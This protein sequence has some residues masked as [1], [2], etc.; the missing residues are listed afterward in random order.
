MNLT[1]ARWRSQLLAG[2]VLGAYGFAI[3]LAPGFTAKGVLCA[4]LLAVPLIWWLLADTSHWLIAFFVA[5]WLLPPLPV[6][7]GNSGPHVS[8]LFAGFGVWMGLACLRSWRFRLDGAA[9][10]IVLVLATLCLSLSMALLYS[11]PAIAELS[12]VRVLLFAISVYVYFFVRSGLVPLEMPR[13]VRI[14]FWTGAASALFACVDFY[15]QFPAPAGYGPQFIWL[16]SGVFRRAQG[17]FYEASTLGNLCAFFLVLIA[18]SFVRAFNIRE[19]FRPQAVS[20]LVLGGCLFSAALVLSYSRGSLINVLVA[21][22]A[23]AVL[24]FSSIRFARVLP[25]AAILTIAGALMLALVAPEFAQAY[26]ARAVASVQY[27]FESPNAV[28]SGRLRTWEIL[29]GFLQSHPLYALLGVGYKTLPYSDFIGATAIADNAYLSALIE[30]GIGG[31]AALLVLNGA[32]LR[33]SYIAARSDAPL[34]S[35]LGTWMFCFWCGQSVQMFTGDLLTY[36]RVLPAYFCILALAE[37]DANPVRR[38]I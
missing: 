30:T 18:V 19:R 24:Q 29:F 35:L 9:L 28:M 10:P 15:Y 1:L 38:P 2:V 8:L 3:A 20:T 21:C 34:R 4:P 31:L 23:L 22:A 37:N 13:L 17:F 7:L 12:A 32:I 11:G 33:S 26:W 5:A 6:T 25:A 27:F 36:W 14:L 16:A